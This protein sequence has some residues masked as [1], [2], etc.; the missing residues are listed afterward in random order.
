MSIL[1]NTAFVAFSLLASTQPAMAANNDSRDIAKIQEVVEKFRTSII[2]KDK[3]TFARLFYSDNP[4]HVIWQFVTDD[5]RV[6]RI[7]KTKPEERK[8]YRVP[9]SNYLTFIVRIHFHALGQGEQ[10][11]EHPHFFTHSLVLGFLLPQS[12]TRSNWMEGPVFSK[13]QCR[14]KSSPPCYSLCPA[15]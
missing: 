12:A 13:F 1:K 3:A 15:A 2:S 6:A 5:A 7:Q 11:A 14:S 9:G 10:N 8:A 4:G